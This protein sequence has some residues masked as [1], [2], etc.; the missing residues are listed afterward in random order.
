MKI[1]EV[2]TANPVCCVSSDPADVAAILMRDEDTGIIPIIKDEDSR[3]VIGVITDR[4]LCLSLIADRERHFLAAGRDPGS[5]PVTEFMTRQLITCSPDDDADRAL[6]L[7]RE[8]QV[9]RILAVDDKGVIQGIVTVADL[10]RRGELADGS[11]RA[12]LEKICEPTGVASKPRAESAAQS[13]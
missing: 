13:S 12:T 6:E 8:N 3:K 9:R 2:M 11:M 4:D 1:S 10:V 7:M 5:L